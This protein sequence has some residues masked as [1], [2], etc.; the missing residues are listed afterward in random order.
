MKNKH[1]LFQLKNTD[2]GKQKLRQLIGSTSPGAWLEDFFLET[3]MPQEDLPWKHLLLEWEDE[4]I[5]MASGSSPDLRR[6]SYSILL[7]SQSTRAA[8]LMW[9]GLTDSRGEIRTLIVKW[10]RSRDRQKLYN[11][12]FR[13][14][15]SDP[16]WEVR[17][18]ARQRIRK[19]FSDL[20]SINPENL[21]KI[22]KIHCIELLEKDSVMDHDLAY[23]FL[24]ESEPGIALNASM[25][26]EKE[27]CLDKLT[28]KASLSDMDDYKRR[29][30]LLEAASRC[31]VTSF[32]DKIENFRSK[33]SLCIAM[34]L[35]ASDGFSR[36][37]E[38][39]IASAMAIKE[40][41]PYINTVKKTAL[42]NLL[43]LTS[44]ESF[45]LLHTLLQ[46]YKTNRE[47]LKVIFQ[48]IPAE[49]AL[50]V[51]PD[52]I[53]FLKDETFGSEEELILSF[54]R[55]P[56][57]YSLRDMHEIVRNSNIPVVVRRRALSVLCHYNDKSTI[58]FILENLSL[59]S[60]TEMVE[61]GI[62]AS[63]WYE[64][65]FLELAENLFTHCDGS[66]KNALMSLLAVSGISRFIPQM[67]EALSDADPST[68]MVAVESL[69]LLKSSSSLEKII[70][71]L[72]DPEE[73]VRGEAAADLIAWNQEETFNELQQ[74]L[75][76]SNETEEVCR[77][78]IDAWGMSG[79]IKS[80]SMLIPLIEKKPELEE[81][82]HHALM[83]KGT[84]EEIRIL[85][86]YFQSGT[87]ALRKSL[88][89]LFIATGEPLEEE[90]LLFLKD[91]D[92]TGLHKSISKIL[93][94]TGYVDIC[95]NKLK[96]R[97]KEVRKQAAEE[98][99]LINTRKAWRGLVL[100]VK[101][102][103]REIRILAIRA[104]VKLKDL[105][106][107][108]IL[109]ELKSDPDKKVKKFTLWA[110]EKIEAGKLP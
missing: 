26:L 40:K 69:S 58:L 12:L 82:I 99:I 88:T 4:L 37:P 23:R 6:Q 39:L 62:N 90:L 77:T 50:E 101:D 42:L 15:L 109:E 56:V 96:S 43:K 97:K 27:G 11:R 95:I 110:L 5:L 91:S 10:F 83:N 61:L 28:G 35:M 18:S 85:L 81:P 48:N 19:D 94:E 14:Y 74:I 75:F 33:G 84:P 93:E 51:Y 24:L 36:I 47:Y 70:P 29:K 107:E 92:A 80:L 102:I 108:R 64:Q 16:V 79:N 34:E 45:S 44:K 46:E 105:D 71:L 49:S 8:R 38:K 57:S 1:P 59:F 87:P 78:I 53:G 66:A 13:M 20:F 41:S 22:E 65:E 30:E 7:Y 72:S 67:E 68:R 86:E 103:N 106:S 63:E 55:L 9:E 21:S 52:L 54:K 100:A 73:S 3:E 31:G 89:A 2:A 98:L 25:Y 76:D 60:R 32:M 17:K 104:M